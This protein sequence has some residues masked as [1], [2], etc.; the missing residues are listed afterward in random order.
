MCLIKLTSQHVQLSSGCNWSQKDNQ[1][2]CPRMKDHKTS[3]QRQDWGWRDSSAGRA[4]AAKP[5]F[6]S[7]M[8]VTHLVGEN[9]SY[10]LF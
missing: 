9:H 4:H 5:D 1:D 10:K 7:S 6:L 2:V 3:L 8:P